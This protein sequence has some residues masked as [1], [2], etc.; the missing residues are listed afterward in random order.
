MSGR[1]SVIDRRV[2]GGAAT[3]TAP[4]RIVAAVRLA[5]PARDHLPSPVVDSP[6]RATCRTHQAAAAA[7]DRRAALRPGQTP[8]GAAGGAV[9]A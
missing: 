9:T 2:R 3:V 4:R 6:L 8:L 7:V 1:P 5:D